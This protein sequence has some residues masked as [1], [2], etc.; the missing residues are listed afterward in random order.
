MGGVSSGDPTVRAN[1]RIS[2]TQVLSEVSPRQTER[3]QDLGNVLQRRR[4]VYQHAKKLVGLDVQLKTHKVDG[5]QGESLGLEHDNVVA[6]HTPGKGVALS[7]CAQSLKLRTIVGI[8]AQGPVHYLTHMQCERCRVY[9]VF[10]IHFEGKRHKNASQARRRSRPGNNHMD[11][12]SPFR[13]KSPP[14]HKGT[15]LQK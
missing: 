12:P 13:D 4:L 8:Y 15:T 1:R 6:V 7:G 10:C 5:V 3:T 2:F 9:I 11:L 14:S